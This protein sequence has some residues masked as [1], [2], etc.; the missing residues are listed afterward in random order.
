MIWNVWLSHILLDIARP[1][2]WPDKLGLAEK[3][4]GVQDGCHLEKR[5]GVEE[6][7]K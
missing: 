2:G 3:I 7:P 4:I 6:T 1:L 5:M